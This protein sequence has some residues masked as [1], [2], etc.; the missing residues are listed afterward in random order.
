[1]EKTLS[2]PATIVRCFV[3][4][5]IDCDNYSEVIEEFHHTKR[6]IAMTFLD[7]PI[8]RCEAAREMVL[9]DETQAQ[10]AREHA[11]PPDRVCPLCG[12]FADEDEGATGPVATTAGY[13]K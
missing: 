12:Y 3:L 6:E 4:A 11:C 8:A 9:T 2:Y 13:K 7:S 1:M 10:C 5:F